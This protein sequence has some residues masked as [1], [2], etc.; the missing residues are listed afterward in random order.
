M[1]KVYEV[2]NLRGGKEE[3]V[4]LLREAIEYASFISRPFVILYNPL[5][6]TNTSQEKKIAL[7]QQR[8]HMNNPQCHEQPQTILKLPKKNIYKKG[9]LKRT[10]RNIKD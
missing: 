3:L 8:T 7:C 5:S 4:G 10:H 2:N 9:I 1:S 6:T